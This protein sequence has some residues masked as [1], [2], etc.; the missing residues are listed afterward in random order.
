[1]LHKTRG[2]VFKTT[3]YGESSVV[4]QVF[5]EKFGLQSY[6]VNGAKKPKAKISRNML[7]PLHLLDM[8]VYHKEGGNVQRIK[9][10][11]NSPVLQSIPYDVIKSSV[12]MFLNEVLYKA[13]RQQ[14]AD[15]NMFD[16]IFSAIQW[17]DHQTTDFNNFHLLFLLKLSRYLGFYPDRHLA[18]QTDYFDL[19]N[20]VF[21]RYK[22]DSALY[23]SPPHTQSF[24][25]L[26]QSNFETIAG[27][28]LSNDERR[29]LIGKLLDYFALHIEGFGNIKSHEVLE[30][31][32]S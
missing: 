3:D 8:V 21:S 15:E 32:L 30:D 26:L 16:F 23:L 27:I 29:Y 18:E 11:K 14:S 28:K 25:L 17:L 6:I 2:I 9:E 31:V 13:V 12:A 7:Q 19:K 5:T 22:P 4:V 24:R 1:M 10:L 20:G